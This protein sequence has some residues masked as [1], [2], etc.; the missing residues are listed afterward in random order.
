METL[1]KDLRYAARM[2]LKG[3]I[4]TL[5]A[6]LALTLGIGA[7]T[8][9]FSVINAVLIKPLP[10]PQ[11]ERL[12]RIFEKSP[13]FQQMSASYLNFLDWRRESKSFEHI[14]LFRYQDFNITGAHE[15]ERVGGRVISADFFSVLGVHPVLGRDLRAEDDVPGAGPVVI[16]SHGFWQR[17]FGGDPNILDK[18]LM[19]NGKVYTVIGIAPAN[20]KFYAAADLFAPIGI[21]DD[22]SLK[23]RDF[24]PGLQVIARLRD[25]VTVFEAENEMQAIASALERQ[26]PASNTGQSV[27]LVSMHEDIVGNIRP[28]LFLL[29]GAVALVLLIACANVANLLLARAATRRKE[30]AI[31]TALGAGR[32]RIVRQLL[33]ENI[34]LSMLGGGLGLLLA[35]WGTD[36]LISLIPDTIPRADDVSLDARV[37]L[38]TFL[39]SVL[40]GTLFGLVPA[41]QVSKPDLNETLKEGGRGAAAMMRPG[42]RSALVVVE[43][44]VALVLLVGAGLLIRS[45]WAVGN[46]TPGVN[47]QNAL[48]MQIPL[49]P[50]VYDDAAKIRAFYDRLLDHLNTSPG[51]EAAGL[52]NNMPFVGEDSEA[53][54]WTGNG[55]R[56]APEEIKWGLFSTVSP[57]YIQAMGIPLVKGR[58]FSEQDSKNS[59]PVTVIDDQ[60]ARGLFHETD[61]VGQRLTIPGNNQFPDIPFEIIGVV[62][63]VKHWGLEFDAGAKIQYQYYMPVAQVPDPFLP[64][65]G[66]SM[67]LVVRTKGDPAEMAGPVKA[68]IHAIDSDQPIATVRTMEQVL[69]DSLAQ[70]RFTMLLLGLFAAL[71]LLLAALGI[72]GVMSYGV[73]QRTRE[74]GVRMALGA[75]G[76]DVL[77]MVVGQ[78]MRLAGTGV[79]IGLIVAFALTRFMTSFLFGISPTDPLTFAAISLFLTGVALAACIVPALRATK[80]DPMSALRYE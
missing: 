4:V 27:T 69:A 26:F 17:H 18:P 9:I 1:L 46:V 7:N 72:Y 2:L 28:V 10:Y 57:G 29:F 33:S 64:L 19:V 20:F 43:M 68:G 80:V 40:T 11:P 16:L 54:F 70:R 31:R 53:P 51:V 23:A 50:N 44:V 62:G 35:I 30:M 55:P 59:R 13:Q 66:S 52:T 37:V 48:T 75:S 39:L 78:G 58:F 34:L 61:P 21:Q 14:A 67:R 41:L 73:A 77:R 5:I 71:A 63:H 60:L 22:V 6:I 45:L 38:F 3:R 49:S 76:A 24:H 74:L 65:L 79:L 56:P 36:A 15:P 25:G 42:V 47:P 12:V 8:A 32:W